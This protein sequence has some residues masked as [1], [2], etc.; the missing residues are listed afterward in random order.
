MEWSAMERW[1]ERRYGEVCAEKEQK[2]QF[3]IL[4]YH[5][6][7][8]RFNENTRQSSVKVMAAYRKSDSASVCLMQQP[9]CLAAPYLKSMVSAGLTTLASFG[10]DLSRAVC[11][12]KTMHVLCIGHGGGSLPLFIASKIPGAIIHIVEIDP[13]VISASIQAMGFPI[14]AAKNTSKHSSPLPHFSIIDQVLWKGIHERLFL[15]E[16]DAET[17]ICNNSNI[18]DLVFIDAYDGDDIFPHSLWDPN[19]KFL[20]ALRDCIHPKH[21]TVVVNL[22]SDSDVLTHQGTNP[23]QLDYLLPMGKY[24]L[25]V[26]RAYNDAL[27]SLA[28]AVSVPWLCNTSLVV[29]RG[30]RGGLTRDRYTVLNTLKSNARVVE[31]MLKLPFSCLQYIKKQFVLID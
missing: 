27:G 20:Q 29:C 3:R 31:D 14:L 8:L 22:H 17:F 5:W 9:H 24:I 21:G 30:G 26:C 12:K 11:Q 10:Y 16:S 28:F 23:E 1:L 6:R 15:Y 7:V 2:E 4:G 19:G 13:V 25:Q 18:Y